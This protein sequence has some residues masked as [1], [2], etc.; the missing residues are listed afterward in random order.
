MTPNRRRGR[1]P[2][3][4]QS[5]LNPSTLNTPIPRY[6]H[7]SPCTRMTEILDRIFFA[8]NFGLPFDRHFRFFAEV[9]VDLAR[10][11]YRSRRRI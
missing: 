5:S 11:S 3:I 7:L 2:E 4:L 9:S 10:K 1:V 6:L 8:F